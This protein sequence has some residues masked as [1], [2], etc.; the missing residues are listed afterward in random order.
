MFKANV[1]KKTYKQL[2]KY[3]GD[4][5][6]I[7]YYKNQLNKGHFELNDFSKEYIANNFTY[8]SKN[9]N[10][11]VK[12][13]SDFG[14]FLQEK[15]KLDFLPKKV[16]IF[17]IIGEMGNSYH[18]YAQFR[19]S[20]NPQLMFISKNYI[21][22][23]D[24][25]EE[26]YNH[27]DI[28]FS[29]YDNLT[30][31]YNRKLKEHQKI[32]ISYLLD[33]KKCILA[34]Q[35]GL[36]KT[37]QAI[38]AAIEGKFNKIL[39]ITTA[40]LKTT[41]LNEI[42][43]FDE[44][45]NITVVNGN[46][47]VDSKKYTIIN[48]DIL[49]K[50]YHIAYEEYE[51]FD[52]K[53]N[54][55]V[56][57]KKKSLKKDTINENLQ[58]SKLYMEGFDCVIIDEAHRLSNSNSNRY[59]ITYDLLQKLKPTAI[60]LLTGTP[61][62]NRP[63]NLYNLLYL[64]DTVVTKDYTYFCKRYCNAREI[65]LSNNKK[66]LINNDASHLDELS[67]KIKHL[68]I[69]RLQSEIPG[70]VEKTIYVKEYDLNKQQREKYEKLWDE[71]IIAQQEKGKYNTEEYRNL[72]EGV[73][74]RQYLAKE[75]IPNTIELTNSHIDYGEKVIIVCNFQEEIDIL[76]QYYKDKAV[77]YNGKMTLK[78]K[79]KAVDRFMNDDKIMVFIAN[80]TAVSLGLSLT[81]S[82]FLVFNSYSWQAAEN[83]QAMDRIYRLTQ[84]KNVICTYQCFTDSISKN[85]FEKVMFKEKIMNA[86]IKSEKEK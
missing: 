65:T 18:C 14:S 50:Y 28:D 32:G 67:E 27:I 40:S 25:L 73:L 37:T 59:K 47:W 29:K 31:K 9:V 5:N 64:L 75:M 39:I 58:K 49:K 78:A 81:V 15:Y 26:K 72:V 35:Q 86:T 12:I 6:L 7:L 83:N 63:I 82:H 57:K 17:R 20:V 23:I 1:I 19:K 79:D 60:F 74:V 36:G 48:Y 84:T 53:T 45:S 51:F 38:V 62:T 4:N 69:R 3:D 70:M 22:D 13:S 11:I 61:L 2:E 10:K 42:C 44:N 52:E 54:S 46:D 34:D 76:K 56:V 55:F 66:I 85:M 30:K 80:L 16:K 68:Y 24:F 77:V 43:Y 41:W 71:Y 21:L 33:H 8:K